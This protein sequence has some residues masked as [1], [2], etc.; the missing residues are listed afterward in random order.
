V[1]LI[2]PRDFAS[3]ET[4]AGLRAIVGELPPWNVPVIVGNDNGAGE[5]AA[6][7]ISLEEAYNGARYRPDAVRRA[8][9]GAGS[10]RE[11]IQL[12][13]FLIS[14][15]EREYL[16]H[17]PIHRSASGP[18]FRPRLAAGRGPA[19]LLVEENPGV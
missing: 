5:S 17:G 18:A 1:V 12:M 19:P 8:L 10:L 11:F 15:A 4:R 16:R 13:P 14:H 9:R 3:A 6:I 2:D 7:R